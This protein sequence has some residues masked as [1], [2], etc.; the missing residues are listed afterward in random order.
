MVASD[1]DRSR[2]V[3]ATHELVDREARL[4]A[5]AEPEPTDS[6]R[7]PLERHSLGGQLQ[8]ALKE[9][10]VGKQLSQCRVDHLDVTGLARKRRP[11]EG[12]DA[13]SKQRPDIRRDKARIC[14]SVLYARL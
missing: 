3:A 12:A 13:A 14:E 6:R 10:V 11:P 8:P 7:Q 9:N 2:H 1:H 5:I 4:R